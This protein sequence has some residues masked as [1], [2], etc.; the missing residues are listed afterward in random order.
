MKSLTALFLAIIILA[1]AYACTCKE[2]STEKEI[3]ELKRDSIE[4]AEEEA[5]MRKEYEELKEEY[6]REKAA[7]QLEQKALKAKNVGKETKADT[8]TLIE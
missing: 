7:F 8:V 1:C 6:Q 4:L 3:R 5:E 2:T